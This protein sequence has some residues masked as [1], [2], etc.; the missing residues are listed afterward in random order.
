MK[1]ERSFLF[2]GL[3]LLGHLATH[4]NDIHNPATP[5]KDTLPPVETKSGFANY[6][7]AFAGQTRIAGAKTTTPFKVEKIAVRLG[8]P[9]AI[10]PMPNGRLMVTLK[11]GAMEILDKDGGLIKKLTGLPEVVYAGQGGLLDVTFSPNYSSDHTMYWCYSEKTDGG[12]ILAVAKGRL[13]ESSGKIDNVTIIFRAA[14]ATKGNLQFGSR[15]VFNKTG[16]LYVSCGEKFAPDIRIQAQDPKSYLGK[17]IKLSKNGAAEII[18]SGHRNPEGLDIDPST[19]EL[20][21]SEFGPH[22]GDEIN[23][24]RPGKNYG[25]P[26]ITYGL[27]YSNDKV[28]DGIQQKAG[29]EQPV[30]YWDPVV[31]PSG[32]CF[33]TGSS[34]PEWKNNLFVACLSGQHVDRLIIKNNK[35]VG[36][37]RLLTET[38]QRFRDVASANNALYA[39]TDDGD[40]Y[41]ITK[42]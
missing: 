17:I 27:E 10:V 36:E 42:Q 21:E 25:W 7:P 40:I 9:F 28:G 14:P 34:I 1:R 4:A 19:G 35:V 12:S 5:A 31:S 37:E 39:I 16:E 38:K 20:W 26:I 2:A 8:N 18:S 29:M 24:I 6:K 13:D 33:Y 32:I 15:L 23:L 41:R 11:S 22:G 3:L 30:Y